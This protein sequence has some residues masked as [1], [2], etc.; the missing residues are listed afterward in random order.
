MEKYL[1]ETVY[2]SRKSFYRKATVYIFAN[3][4]RVLESYDSIV[5]LVKG[6]E[7]Q[8][9]GNWDVSPT[10]LRHVKEFAKQQHFYVET[11][12]DLQKFE[13]P[14]YGDGYYN[15]FDYERILGLN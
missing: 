10:T 8:V 4:T 6:N 11:K 9:F 2:D 7:L 13:V 15:I 12:K 5:A 3:G 1:L 14:V